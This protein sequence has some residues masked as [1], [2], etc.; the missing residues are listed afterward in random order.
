MSPGSH[1]TRLRWLTMWDLWVSGNFWSAESSD[2]IQNSSERNIIFQSMTTPVSANTH[3][4]C[5]V[6]GWSWKCLLGIASVDATTGT[7]Q[8]THNTKFHIWLDKYENGT[9]VLNLTRESLK[10]S[11]VYGSLLGSSW[12]ETSWWVVGPNYQSMTE[13]PNFRALL[14]YWI[15][16][17]QGHGWQK[18]P[19]E[20][21]KQTAWSCWGSWPLTQLLTNA[22]LDGLQD[23]FISNRR[24]GMR[25]TTKGCCFL[26]YPQPRSTNAGS[27]SSSSVNT[28]WQI[29]SPGEAKARMKY[30]RCWQADAHVLLTQ[31]CEDHNLKETHHLPNRTKKVPPSAFVCL[32]YAYGQQAEC[33][34]LGNRH[35]HS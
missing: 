14:K 20:T 7:A 19:Q 18:V 6:L 15:R 24:N 25:P 30:S 3:V 12:A 33:P 4:L 17:I 31:F 34:S 35:H 21:S 13:Y 22:T 16:P 27:G 32:F 11:E 10:P 28:H 26:P 5:P 9:L 1:C 29:L 2:R 23:L 8:Y